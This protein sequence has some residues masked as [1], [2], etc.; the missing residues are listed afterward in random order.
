MGYA[1][2]VRSASGSGSDGDIAG[3]SVAAPLAAAFGPADRACEVSAGPGLRFEPCF[4]PREPV[5]QESAKATGRLGA[6]E[7]LQ[8][9]AVDIFNR[10]P[11]H[12][13]AFLVA[14]GLV[15]DYPVEINHFLSAQ[16]ASP[17]KFGE[18]LGEAFPLAQNLRLELLN[19]LPLL[20]TGIVSALE[21]VFREVVAPGD[22]VRANRI[23]QGIAHFWWLQHEEEAKARRDDAGS[24]PD[25]GSGP[26]SDT[27]AQRLDGGAPGEVAGFELQRGVLCDA[28]LHGLM[29]SALMLHRWFRAGHA[30]TLNEWTQMNAGIEVGGVDVSMRIQMGI[31]NALA[32]GFKLPSETLAEP[33]VRLSPTLEG[34]AFVHFNGRAQVSHNGVPSDFPELRPRLLAARG[35]VFSA[36]RSSCA[37]LDPGPDG[38]GFGG[39]LSRCRDGG[40]GGAAAV[41]ADDEGGEELAWLSLH[42]WFLFFA[43]TPPGEAAAAGAS[44]AGCGRPAPYGFVS[45]RRAALRVTD[46]EGRRLVLGSRAEAQEKAV[47][48]AVNC[49]EWLELCLLLSDGRFQPMEAPRLQLRFQEAAAFEA[50][51]A[52]IG[53]AC[54]DN[55]PSKPPTLGP[56]IGV[57]AKPPGPNDRG[58]V[59]TQ[60]SL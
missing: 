36:G 27:V 41:A 20:G 13:V 26:A 18:Y 30:M 14:A 7:E 45:L 53:E 42:R 43:A 38:G 48:T 24:S 50:W 33:K 1:A 57:Q 60:T 31:Y 49:D 56:R 4:V 12:G 16:P 5:M 17:E 35:G 44:A 32:D 2:A 9:L 11:G 54:A 40:G 21:I 47:G 28:T 37:I 19:S 15:R 39:R 55:L 8:Q 52:I 29:F 25:A 58:G 34:A 59:D 23:V 3:P 22:F 46:P 51:A 6:P 10:S